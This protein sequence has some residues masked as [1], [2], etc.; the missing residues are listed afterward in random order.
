MKFFLLCNPKLQGE[1]LGI[2]SMISG[3]D[4]PQ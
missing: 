3:R 4:L 1:I 2:E